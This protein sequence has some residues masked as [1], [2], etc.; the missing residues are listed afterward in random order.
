MYDGN[1]VIS[2]CCPMS[3]QPSHV[4][5]HEACHNNLSSSNSTYQSND[6]N[7]RKDQ[8]NILLQLF[9]KDRTIMDYLKT[10]EDQKKI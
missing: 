6:L 4:Y 2:C 9:E 3:S 5:S 1:Q 7:S 10:I 8:N